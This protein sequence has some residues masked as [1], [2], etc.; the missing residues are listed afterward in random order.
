[1]P[2][3][4]QTATLPDEVRLYLR[5]RLEDG[6]LELPMLPT[7]ASEVLSMC[8][9]VETD[10][11]KLSDVLHRDPTLA[12]HVLR[13]ANSSLYMAQM[14]IVSLQQAI[15]RLGFRTLSEIAMTVSMNQRIFTSSTHHEVMQVLWEHSVA[16][17]HFSKEIARVRRRNVESAFL[18]GLL[19][20]VGKPVVLS[21]L[22]DAATQF[23]IR[24]GLPALYAAMQEFHLLGGVAL[25]E[26]WR[27]P[28]QVLEAVAWHHDYAGAPTCQ[29]AVMQTCLADYLA[30][31]VALAGEGLDE[32]TLRELPVLEDL[33]LYPDELEELVRA[34]P[35]VSELVELTR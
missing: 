12:G 7:V 5:R 35:R 21:L 32:E 20:D 24:F 23:K 10:A 31:F 22:D 9:S 26:R 17:A 2:Q 28:V 18:C 34:R 14:P 16:A 30:Y 19:H 33:N 8:E 25:A 13:V 29:E 11:A 15:S 1:M 27:L 4:L 3:I 6:S